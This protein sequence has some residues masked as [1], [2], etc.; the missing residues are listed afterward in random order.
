MFEELKLFYAAV[1][2]LFFNFFINFQVKLM[3]G[4]ITKSPFSTKKFS[5]TVSLFLK[6]LVIQ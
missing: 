2:M 5:K 4:N 3:I 6:N 1:K